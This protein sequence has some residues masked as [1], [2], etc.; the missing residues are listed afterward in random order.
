MLF[1]V[2]LPMLSTYSNQEMDKDFRFSSSHVNLSSIYTTGTYT[3][4]SHSF[5]TDLRISPPSNPVYAI[6][7]TFSF[8]AGKELLKRDY[9]FLVI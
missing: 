5:Y 8:C 1:I 4:S 3:I 6:L 7:V 2:N 9:L